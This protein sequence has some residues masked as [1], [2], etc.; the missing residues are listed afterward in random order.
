MAHGIDHAT[1]IWDDALAFVAGSVIIIAAGSGFALL[2]WVAI[3]IAL[4][5]IGP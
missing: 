3:S 2:I 5:P 1:R 4:T